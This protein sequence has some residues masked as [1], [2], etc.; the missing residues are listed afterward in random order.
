MSPRILVTGVGG[1]PGLDLAR[2]LVLRG[3]QVIAVDASR[4]AAGLL[5]PGITAATTHR[6]DHPRFRG[7]LLDLCREHRPDAVISAVEHDLPAILSL[8]DEL[9]RMETRTWLPGADSVQSCTDK[10]A[11]QKVMIRHAIPTPRT[12]LPHELHDVPVGIGL[13]VKPRHGHGSQNIVFCRTPAQALV[14]CQIIPDPVVQERVDGREFTADAIVDDTGRT[15]LVLRERLLVKGGLSHAGRTFADAQAAG[16]VTA[17]LS[18]LKARGACC[19]QGFITDRPGDDRILLTEVNVRVAG[20][21]PIA[22][23]AGADITGQVL[24]GHLGEVVDHNRLA[25]EPDVTVTR[26]VETLHIDR[27]RKKEGP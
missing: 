16:R 1:A 8:R 11:F 18:A 6:A 26:C 24:A 25:Y 22:E 20:G 10:A 5:L 23:A 4:H 21:F 17:A 19:V 27:N 7:Q 2:A 3:C 13:V 14:L 12:W 15:S 9:A